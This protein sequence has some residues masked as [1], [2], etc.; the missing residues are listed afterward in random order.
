MKSIKGYVGTYRSKAFTVRAD[1]ANDGKEAVVQ[2]RQL[3]QPCEE[4]FKSKGIV[5]WSLHRESA[6]IVA[7]I[8]TPSN[9][10]AQKNNRRSQ[11]DMYYALYCT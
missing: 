5:T 6:T 3:I 2:C 1:V 4:Q 10:S 8:I 9:N 11:A 7:A